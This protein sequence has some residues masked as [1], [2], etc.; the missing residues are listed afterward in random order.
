MTIERMLG[1]QTGEVKELLD[2]CF[3]KASWSLESV[4]SQ[5]EKSDSVCTVAVEDNAVVGYLAFEQIADEGCIIELAV[6][7]GYRRRGIAHKLVKN[8]LDSSAGLGAVFL[9]VRE[10]N[11][12]AISLYESL[13]F[14]R[15]G[16]RRDYYDSPKENAAIYRLPLHKDSLLS[17]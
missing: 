16:V 9:E 8:M 13:G 7:P 14:E 12:E 6:H 4:R 17:E 5:L 2:I 10:S 15:I 3:G 11:S 1:G